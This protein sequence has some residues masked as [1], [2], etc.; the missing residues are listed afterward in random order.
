MLNVSV[1][2]SRMKESITTLLLFSS[3]TNASTVKLIDWLSRMKESTVNVFVFLST[4]I[5]S[6]FDNIP[7]EVELRIA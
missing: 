4:R 7:F 2:V 1:N 6:A 3:S 5:E